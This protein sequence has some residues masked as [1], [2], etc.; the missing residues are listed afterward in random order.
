MLD[1]VRVEQAF[2]KLLDDLVPVSERVLNIDTVD[3]KETSAAD[4]ITR[5]ETLSFFGTRRVVLVRRAEELRPADQDALGAY[6]EPAPPPSALILAAIKLDQRRR[7]YDVANR[8][9]SLIRCGPLDAEELPAWVRARAQQEGKTIGHEAARALML[10]VGDGLR[11]LGLEIAKLTAY[12]GDRTDITVEDV[13]AIAS[14]T[15][16]ARVFE[17]TDAVGFRQ[18][19]RALELLHTLIAE[20]IAPLLILF[21]LE[22][23]IRMLLRAQALLDRGVR[24]PQRGMSPDPQVRAALGRGA[25]VFWKYRN[26]LRKFT[27]LRAEE[28]LG[29]LLEADAAI[30]T[31][32]MSP[33][34]VLETLIVRLCGAEEPGP[35]AR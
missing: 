24:P 8:T 29:V 31:S 12:V 33:R 3:A 28:I 16:E 4:I 14:R 18:A 13:R 32:T 10:L 25:G 34:L 19:G 5:C 30:K 20:G 9:G 1:E 15:A 6:L 11:E 17:L 21:M 35:A 27:R 7:L 23:Q 22:Q 26:Q 2:A